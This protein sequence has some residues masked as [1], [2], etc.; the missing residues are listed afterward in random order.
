M[1]KVQVPQGL[2]ECTNFIGGQWRSSA[3]AEHSDVVSPYTGK[4]L[5][6]IVHATEKDIHEAIELASKS[7]VAWGALSMK[8]RAQVM[9]RFREELLRSLDSISNM[10]SLESG[11]LIAEARAGV[12]KG[13]EV[14]EFALSLQNLDVGGKMEVSSG[15]TC[16]YK[17]EPLGVVAGITPF[18]FPAM[19]PMWMIPIAIATGNSFVWKPSDKTPLTSQLIAQAANA[20]G[21]PAGVLTILQGGRSV[22]EALCRH[23]KIEAIGFVG[24][25]AIAKSVYQLGTNHGKRVQALGGAK[26]HI[27]LMPDADPE[28]AAQGILAS[29]TGCAGQRCMAASVLLAVKGSEHIV[30]KIAERAKKMRA[31]EDVGAIIS[32]ESLTR[33]E[34]ALD[35]AAAQG[36]KIKVDGRL[37]QKNSE[38]P[39]GEFAQGFWMAPSILENVKPNTEAA[40][41]ELFGPVLSVMQ[42]NNLSEA[43]A[44]ENSNPYGNAASVFTNSGAVAE[45]VTRRSRAGMV[46]INIGVPVPREPFSFGGFYASKFGAGDITGLGGVEFWTRQKKIT[47]KWSLPKD[48]NWMN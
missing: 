6:H 1:Q 3:G 37:T 47:S 4:K 19:V 22:A 2:V 5:G 41:D 32:K 16:E 42:C 40:C 33:L 9:F 15:V 34:K 45:E 44:I 27:I 36:A 31:G 20:A 8:D 26:N 10:V 24:S 11:K 43:L 23:E 14:L 18:N 39:S 30:E 12:L 28:I 38:R 35:T 17:R 48:Q 21:I 13:V 7:Q 25:T 29:F 46:G